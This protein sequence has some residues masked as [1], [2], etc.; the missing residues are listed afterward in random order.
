MGER[1]CDDGEGI[2]GLSNPDSYRESKIEAELS[3]IEAIPIAIGRTKL[4]QN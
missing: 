1:Y 2:W 4:R 3:K